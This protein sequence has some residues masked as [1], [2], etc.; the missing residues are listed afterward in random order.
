MFG[1]IAS[2]DAAKRSAAVL[3][4]ARFALNKCCLHWKLWQSERAQQPRAVGVAQR[5]S[6]S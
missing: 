2:G 4:S 6:L 5:S 3:L 1:T